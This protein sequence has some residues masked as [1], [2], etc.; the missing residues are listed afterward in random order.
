MRVCTDS[1]TE[2]KNEQT[3]EDTQQHQRNNAPQQRG[4]PA[5]RRTRTLQPAAARAMGNAWKQKFVPYF[6]SKVRVL[7]LGLDASGKTT[8]LYKLK[9][10][11]GGKAGEVEAF[12]PTIGF[13][14]EQLNVNRTTFVSFDVGGRSPIRPLW[15]VFAEGAQALVYVVD[16]SDQ[17]RLDEAKRELEYVLG[18]LPPK[19]GLL[20]L[21]NKSDLPDAA[22]KQ[23]VS[24]ALNLSAVAAS[25]PHYIHETC[26]T[27]G[28]G[29]PNALSWLAKTLSI[30]PIC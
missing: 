9:E 13:N 2:R 20:V 8:L 4:E 16:A 10:S 25:R 29:V 18:I 17:Y 26:I 11:S 19:A 12:I 21:A 1:I 14:C 23:E 27:T 7:L 15:K 6:E 22:T 28:D 3:N 30:S 24:T 5:A